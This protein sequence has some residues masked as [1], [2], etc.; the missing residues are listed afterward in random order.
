MIACQDVS[1]F[2]QNSLKFRGELG[3]TPTEPIQSALQVSP[4]GFLL[5]W[6]CSVLWWSAR[7]WFDPGRQTKAP[8][9]LDATRDVRWKKWSQVPFCCLLH[10]ALLI[11]CSVNS[12]VAAI[13]FVYPN[14]LRFW[15]RVWCAWNLKRWHQL[16][17]KYRERPTLCFRLI[18]DYTVGSLSTKR[19]LQRK[20]HPNGTPL[21]TPINRGE[22]AAPPSVIG[23]DF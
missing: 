9:T 19:N 1:L 3:L 22:F 16:C 8:Y 17:R 13:G 2:R 5:Q 21:W 10:H 12:P 4:W 6:G 15:R 11:A 7:W 18:T 20:L 23:S 14:F